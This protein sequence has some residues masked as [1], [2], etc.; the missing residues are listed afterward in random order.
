MLEQFI[1]VKSCIEKKKKSQTQKKKKELHRCVIC[2]SVLVGNVRALS[3]R[4]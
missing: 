2:M 1:M 3:S 4:N